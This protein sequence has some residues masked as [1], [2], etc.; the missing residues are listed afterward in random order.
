MPI[1]EEAPELP[2]RIALLVSYTGGTRLSVNG[3]RQWCQFPAALQSVAQDAAQAKRGRASSFH[4]LGAIE[5]E[6]GAVK[7]NKIKKIKHIKI[8]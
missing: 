2:R 1:L 7:Q 6:P 4:L 8:K 3:K 5:F